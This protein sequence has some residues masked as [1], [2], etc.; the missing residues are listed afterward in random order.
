MRKAGPIDLSGLYGGIGDGRHFYQQLNDI[1]SFSDEIPKE[2]EGAQNR[3]DFVLQDIKPHSVT[4][5]LII[6]RILNDMATIR[7][8]DKALQED[9]SELREL[10]AVASYIHSCEI[11]PAWIYSRLKVIMTSLLGESPKDDGGSFD[12]GIPWLTASAKTAGLVKEVLQYWLYDLEGD[13]EDDPGMYDVKTIQLQSRN[14]AIDLDDLAQSTASIAAELGLFEGTEMLCPP[15]SLLR[16][17]EPKLYSMLSGSS[18]PKVCIHHMVW[19]LW[20]VV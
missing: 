5:V 2:Y 13:L 17:K 11:M 16:M 1:T 12:F 6:L 15:M 20:S 14:S 9:E 3:F 19:R 18:K 10:E 7:S 4:R 8:H